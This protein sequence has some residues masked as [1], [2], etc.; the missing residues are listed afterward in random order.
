MP[1]G[2][3]HEAL[4]LEDILHRL[5]YAADR[6]DHERAGRE[7][8]ALPVD[9]EL[10]LAVLAFVG[11]RERAAPIRVEQPPGDNGVGI[12]LEVGPAMLA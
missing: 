2:K 12:V 10:A 1:S 5:V 9:Y 8:V 7:S 11:F 3:V 6:S 4:V